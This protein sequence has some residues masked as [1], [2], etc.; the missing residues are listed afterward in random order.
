MITK[1]LNITEHFP[2]FPTLKEL[3]QPRTKNTDVFSPV[4]LDIETTGLSRSAAELY[5]IGAVIPEGNS[6]MLYQW[7]AEH[8]SEEPSLLRA[9]SEKLKNCT[10]LISY[11][12]DRFDLPFLETKAASYGLS[13][14]SE[15][16]ESLDLYLLLKPLQKLL[17]LERMKQP[18]LEE[19]LDI[20]NRVYSDGKECISL[21]RKFLKTRDTLLADTV[22]GHN[23]E[24]LLGLGRISEMT[25]YLAFTEGICHAADASVEDG[26]LL[27]TLSLPHSL[28]ACFSCGTKDFYLTGEDRQ[29]RLIVH[30]ADG[31]FRIYYSNYKDYY[32]MASED[33]AIPKALG[34]CMDKKLLS[35]A[36][37]DTCYTWFTCTEAFLSDCSQQDQY[38]LHT[39]PYLISTLR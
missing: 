37:R 38:L 28:P 17:K 21:Y 8:S 23:L 31:R 2:A 16:K 11:N 9:F 26:H 25:A 20:K 19:F 32:Y 3:L 34:A 12:G 29:A 6:W 30:S 33:T 5:L 24:D 14:L 1:V 13:S 22:T 27:M 18:Y 15:G 36:T 7:M 4:F 39:L 10:C 35:S